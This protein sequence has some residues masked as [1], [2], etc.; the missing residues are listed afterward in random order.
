MAIVH[1]INGTEIHG[2]SAQWETE[3]IGRNYDNTIRYSPFMSLTWGIGVMS[4]ADYIL[5]LA[6]QDVAITE[7]KTSTY[8][9][10]NDQATYTTV[11]MGIING[12]AKGH[13]VENISITFKVAI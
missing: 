6:L 13:R 7:L 4:K 9:T 11:Q 10:R 2:V 5:L 3:T 12:T 1:S 8:G